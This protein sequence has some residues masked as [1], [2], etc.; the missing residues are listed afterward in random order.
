M[1]ETIRLPHKPDAPLSYQFVP[2]QGP[3][4][5][6]HLIVY[7]NGLIAP[8][9]GWRATIDH[10][11]R[12]WD[13]GGSRS[14]NHPALLTYD[15][16]GQGGS[17]RDPADDQ[18]G[19]SHDIR[20][21]VADLHVLAQEIRRTKMIKDA[22]A[23][24]EDDGAA[25]ADQVPKPKLIF[26]ANSI[27]CV[28]GRFYAQTYPGSTAALLFLDSNIANSDQVSL[29]PDPD[30][31]GFDPH[32]L[33]PPDST[34]ADLRRTR[35]GYAAHF[36]PSAPNPE[37]LDRRNIISLLPLSDG[38][39]LRGAEPDEGTGPRI[40]VVGHDWATFAEEGLRGSMNVPEG[41]TN[42]YVNPPWAAYNEGLARLTSADR[43]R[44]PVIATGCGHFI[45]K[46]DPALVA[47]LTDD[48][49][50]NIEADSAA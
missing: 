29:F 13:E 34:V 30:A 23:S 39:P 10:L 7:L 33:L 35:A 14:A 28:I 8:Q 18:H 40:T 1:S 20:E 49:L 38:P 44:G 4:S 42:R 43:A 26:V 9:S 47:E 16:Y 45:Q 37:H 24:N 6:T 48:L 3:L 15:R 25:A 36:H 19:G 31:P 32:V 2:G 21:V 41:L 27:G 11:R 5:T 17:A 46:D 12:R 22:D 50:R